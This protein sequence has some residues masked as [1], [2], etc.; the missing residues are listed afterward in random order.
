MRALISEL[1]LNNPSTP[2][3]IWIL[4][5]VHG[6]HSSVFTSER[7]RLNVLRSSVPR[8]FWGMVEFWTRALYPGLP[9][10]FLNH[11]FAQRWVTG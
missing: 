5:E 1:S 9:G 11:M 7:D 8:E 3:D 4:V 6:R 2:Y 10:K